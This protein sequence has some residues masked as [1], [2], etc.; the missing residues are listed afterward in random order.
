M[1]AAV[2]AAPGRQRRGMGRLQDQVPGGVD[3][4]GLGPGMAAP[5]HENHRARIL[6]HDPPGHHMD[7]GVGQGLPAQPGVGP[8]P[9]QLRGQHGIEQQHALARPAPEV[10]GGVAALC[11]IL[12]KVPGDLLEDIAQ[13]GR[14]GHPVGHGKGQPVGLSR[15]VVRVLSQD[16]HAHGLGRGQ[17]QGVKDLTARRA[18]GVARRPGGTLQQGRTVLG[19][20]R[21]Q[22]LPLPGN[23][24]PPA[25]SQ[26]RN[27]AAT[28]QAANPPR[29]PATR[30][31]P[32]SRRRR[33]LSQAMSC[34][35][36]TGLSLSTPK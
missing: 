3:E 27:V 11:G 13:R 30:I 1:A 26:L 31:R 28:A 24:R 19:K 20:G 17:L 21:D 2:E 4:P 25:H 15:A 22:A 29:N 8:G 10:S 12:P 5:E 18:Q 14:R 36:S 16:D 6:G 33:S 9:A 35:P 23:G 34:G 32:R 7:D